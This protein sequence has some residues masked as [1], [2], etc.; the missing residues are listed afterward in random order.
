MHFQLELIVPFI[1]I[2]ALIVGLLITYLY[3][4][5]LFHGDTKID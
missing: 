2:G 3:N 5:W 1:L 4:P